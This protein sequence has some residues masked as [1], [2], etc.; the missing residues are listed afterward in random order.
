MFYDCYT[1]GIDMILK[2]LFEISLDT[3]PA[4]G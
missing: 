2:G 4:R 1:V 3:F